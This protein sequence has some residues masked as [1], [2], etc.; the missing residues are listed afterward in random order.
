MYDVDPLFLFSNVSR[1]ERGRGIS[2]K[3]FAQFSGART[4]PAKFLSLADRVS[5][6]AVEFQINEPTFLY[7]RAIDERLL[8]SLYT[9]EYTFIRRNKSRGTKGWIRKPT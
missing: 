1:E 8:S 4:Q 5:K 3:K 9:F 7:F 6:L 2:E